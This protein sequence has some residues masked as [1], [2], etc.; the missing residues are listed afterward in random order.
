MES[1]NIIWSLAS[2]LIIIVLFETTSYFLLKK[3]FY[4]KGYAYIPKLEH[5]EL[6]YRKMQELPLKPWGL[7]NPDPP[8]LLSP[9]LDKRQVSDLGDE[10][11]CISLWG[12]SFTQDTRWGQVI[13]ENLHCNITNYGMG[14]YGIDQAFQIYKNNLDDTAKI[15]VLSFFSEDI[16]RH[17]TRNYLAWGSNPIKYGA[18]VFAAKF[19]YTLDKDGELVHLP[20]EAKSFDEFKAAVFNPGKFLPHDYLAAGRKSGP[21]FV[22]FPYTVALLKI[23]FNWK[24]RPRLSGLPYH[25][26]LF[27]PGHGSNALEISVKIVEKFVQLAHKRGVN[28]IVLVLPS[29]LDFEH[30]RKTGNWI[31]QPL[32]DELNIRAIPVHDAGPRMLEYVPIEDF[33]SMFGA[34]NKKEFSFFFND[35][36]GHYS[37]K[38]YQTLGK[39]ATKIIQNQFSGEFME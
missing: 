27:N 33:C 22:R 14:G 16:V 38:G 7:G 5:T 6:T 24:L 39:L 37:L 8:S 19:R 30:F 29:V 21:T 32:L 3:V 35:C 13:A 18:S 34:N 4:P 11:V 17:V 12:E 31:Y 23:F 15:V 26:N 10:Q 36:G 20:A 2:L 9:G 1:R 28:P 25:A